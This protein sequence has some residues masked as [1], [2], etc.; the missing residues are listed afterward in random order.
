MSSLKDGWTD[1]RY[2]LH[3]IPRFAVDNDDLWA[4]F[5]MAQLLYNLPIY[6]VCVLCIRGL[7]HH[8]LKIN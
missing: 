7:H 5:S 2:Q 3:Y 4:C 6:S 1:R 8:S